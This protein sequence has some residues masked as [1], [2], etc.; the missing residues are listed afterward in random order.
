MPK[1][2]G[3]NSC[4]KW[5]LLPCGIWNLPEPGME[6]PSPAL[7]GGFL[8]PGPT[9]KFKRGVFSFF[10]NEVAVGE[11]LRLG[12]GCQW[13]I[14]WVENWNFQCHLPHF[15]KGGKVESIAHC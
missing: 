14:P 15:Q 12:T 9:G 13:N 11:H 10:V 7:A 6:P 4:G 5:A 8:T 1:C 2:V 3:F